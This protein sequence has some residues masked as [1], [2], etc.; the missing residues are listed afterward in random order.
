MGLGILSVRFVPLAAALT[1]ALLR[2][3]E[4]A[5]RNMS[6]TARNAP[7]R[8]GIVYLQF[9][10]LWRPKQRCDACRDVAVQLLRA[11][12][13]DFQSMRRLQDRLMGVMMNLTQLPGEGLHNCLHM[14]G[15]DG[16][17]LAAWL[18]ILSPEWGDPWLSMRNPA[19]A[20]LFEELDAYV[21]GQ[22]R[23][24]STVRR[25]FAL[26]EVTAYVVKPSNLAFAAQRQ[27]LAQLPP[28][29]CISGPYDVFRDPAFVGCVA[30]HDV[31][32][33]FPPA[34][35]SHDYEAG[36]VTD[37]L[38]CRQRIEGDGRISTT[39]AWNTA[40]R[41]EALRGYL[42]GSTLPASWP[43]A[44]EEYFEHVDVLSSAVETHHAGAEIFTV[45][46]LGSGR[47]AP[48]ASR[49]VAAWRRLRPGGDCRVGLVEVQS[50]LVA[51]LQASLGLFGLADCE[52][53]V[54]NVDISKTGLAELLV[55]FASVDYLDLDAQGHEFA[56][57]LS[58]R[59]FL[60]ER[61][62]R[63]HVGTHTR[64]IHYTLERALKEDGWEV[65][66]S[67]PPLSFSQTL[68]GRIA[69]IDGVLAVVSK[70]ERWLGTIRDKS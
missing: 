49:A 40:T 25:S 8:G 34:G 50:S 38:G 4:A 52:T 17:R 20:A 68:Y 3:V 10:D 65:V 22:H 1:A 69:F 66:W 42:Q 61:V 53:H 31:F 27:A 56:A 18:F 24:G 6:R 46:E 36:F 43:F 63:V 28:R 13:V 5:T 48:W 70:D 15:Q 29:N 51:E 67:F 55:G 41:I 33:G 12:E 11:V 35:L 14:L 26:N 44:D 64:E 9:R 60:Q 37:F 54:W 21:G 45:V 23:M 2:C 19:S 16:A 62:R 30:H 32:H 59:V 39:A 58:A 7:E 47:G 57:I